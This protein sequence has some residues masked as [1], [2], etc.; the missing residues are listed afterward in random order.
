MGFGG[1]NNRDYNKEHAIFNLQFLDQASID[2]TPLTGLINNKFRLTILPRPYIHIP[3]I[4]KG[5]I[6][7]I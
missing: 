1:G 4:L 3:N 6:A 2:D 5:H 7:S